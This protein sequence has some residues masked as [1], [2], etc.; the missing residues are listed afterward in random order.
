MTDKQ[1]LEIVMRYSDRILELVE[2]IGYGDRKFLSPSDVEGIAGAIVLG[3]IGEV[4]K[5]TK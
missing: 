4:E 2:D 3:I 1:K 5:G